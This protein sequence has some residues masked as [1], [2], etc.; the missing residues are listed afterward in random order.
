MKRRV[1]F[2]LRGK[3]GDTIVAFATVRAY[4]DAFPD[5]DVTVLVRANYAPLLER[6]MGMRVIGF[7]SRLAMYA[8]LALLRWL[9]APFD[10]LLVL[11]GAG[12]PIAALGRK[13]RAQR[14]VFLDGRFKDIYPEWPEIP[15]KHQHF[16][17]AWRVARVFAPDLPA[18]TR[19][20]IPSLAARRRAAGAIGIA[21]VSDEPRRTMAPGLVRALAAA[22]VARHAGQPVHVLVNPADTEAKGLLAAALPAGASLRAFHTLP[23]LVD[24]LCVLEHLHATDTGA[25]HLAAAM[26]VPLTT[27]FG[28][29][30]PWKNGF[31][32]QPDLTR[33][34]L[35][36]LG[37][38]HCEEKGCR[39]PVCL[40]L[41]VTGAMQLP[42]IP[43]RVDE[44]P[45]GC[46]LR[47][48][49]REGL[50]TVKVEGAV[51]VH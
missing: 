40:E 50:E 2:V 14:K 19:S 51:P 9:E 11:L 38:E 45:P 18:P 22:L 39:R 43:Y 36:A 24:E 46:L 35:A 42:A 31:P 29:T 7:A 32:E 41:P 37:G 49:P 15:A 25:Y 34:R 26:G 20:R 13:V 17:P 4:A 28:P 21:P 48:H 5:D 23:E 47:L 1:L 27:Y 10:A 3:L 16:E 12:P 30:Q 6:E 33:V 8:R 44:T